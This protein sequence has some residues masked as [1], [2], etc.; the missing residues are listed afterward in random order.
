MSEG[1]FRAWITL[2]SNPD[3]S[4]TVHDSD[5]MDPADTAM[6]TGAPLMREWIAGIARASPLPAC[7]PAQ[8]ILKRLKLTWEKRK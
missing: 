2:A 6:F 4:W 5:Q 1:P 3:G 7:I 8:G